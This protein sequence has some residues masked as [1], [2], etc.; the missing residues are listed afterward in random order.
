VEIFDLETSMQKIKTV[1]SKWLLITP[2]SGL[3]LTEHVRNEL[4]IG[5]VRFVTGSK[6]PRI[7]KRLGI[8]TPI[9][10]LQNFGIQTPRSIKNK[11]REFFSSSKTYA[12]TFFSGTQLENEQDCIRRIEEAINI[13]SFSNLGFA[14]RNFNSKISIKTSDQVGFNQI[15]ILDK[16]QKQF[17]LEYDALHPVPIEL[18]NY[19]R[20][21]QSH[22]YF[23]QLID[24]INDKEKIK[25]KW[26]NLLTSVARMVG[27]GLN[28]HDIPESFLKNVIALEMLLV[29]QSERIED[30]LI[31]RS[32][33][34]LD[35][36]EHWVQDDI[37]NRIRQVYGKRCKYVHD[38]EVQGITKQDLI[39]TDDLLFNIFNNILRNIDKIQSK[40]DLIEFS[41]K[42]KCEK[43]LQIKSKFQFPRF[44]YVRKKYERSDVRK[45]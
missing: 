21:Y 19:W 33:Y 3:L 34:F 9:S 24:I 5:N 6:L 39:F 37:E 29:N 31:E 30:K 10:E 1:D 28:S 14:T 17:S 41:E 45:M 12:I 40:G 38:G 42:Y 20:K 8:L 13:V 18:N 11:V 16:V 32:G 22:H 27:K 15:I 26:K 4:K 36:S 2:I 44:Q 43:K 7:R 35:W 25:S 23:L